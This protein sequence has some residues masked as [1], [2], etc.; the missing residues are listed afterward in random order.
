M[1]SPGIEVYGARELRAA[2]RRM[3]VEGQR[4]ALKEAHTSVA[5]LVVDKSQPRGNTAQKRMA[6]G[7]VPSGTTTKAQVKLRNTAANPYLVRA[8]MGSYKRT[9]WYSKARYSSSPPQWLEWVGNNWNLEAGTGPYVI[10]DVVHDEYSN[11]LDT[12]MDEMRK[13]ARKVG[14]DLG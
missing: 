4:E 6:D 13:A 9:G 10:A 1:P 8:F 7:M 14:L 2:M 3:G 5:D 12:Y 11:I